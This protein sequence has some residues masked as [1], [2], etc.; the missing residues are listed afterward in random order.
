MNPMNAMLTGGLAGL[1][2][3]V[4]VL[5]VISALRRRRPTPMAR[6]EP[7]VHRRPTT[8]RLLAA[9]AGPTSEGRHVVGL[10]M[11]STASPLSLGRL[12]DTLGSFADSVRRRLP[13]SRS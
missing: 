3:A 10:P 13:R 1:L 4:G 9:P 6:L 7:Y 5:S 12:M 8:S 11:A 2:G